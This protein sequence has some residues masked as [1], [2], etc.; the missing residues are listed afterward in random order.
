MKNWCGGER[1]KK[2]RECLGRLS[3]TQTLSKLHSSPPS[4]PPQKDTVIYI[5]I[6]YYRHLL[7]SISKEYNLET[8]TKK[9]KVFGFVGA[10]P[11]GTKN[12]YKR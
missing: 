10:D 1:I 12:Y 2:T 7:Y 3:C 9:T 8:A 4:A 11:L 5:I 6:F